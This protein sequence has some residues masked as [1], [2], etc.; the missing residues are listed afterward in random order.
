MAAKLKK[1]AR[2]FEHSMLPLET[3]VEVIALKGDKAIKKIMPYGKALKIKKVN[4]WYYKFYQIGY[5]SY[6]SNEQ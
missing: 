3:E 6:E 2:K 1:A 4:G 5:S